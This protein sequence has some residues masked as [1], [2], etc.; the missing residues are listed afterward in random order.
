MSKNT[1]KAI[2]RRVDAG[3]I[4]FAIGEKMYYVNYAR[5]TVIHYLE[6]VG[7][8]QITY[9]DELPLKKEVLS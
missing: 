8:P 7:G 5:H 4:E 6:N 3:L 9:F 1:L 2:A